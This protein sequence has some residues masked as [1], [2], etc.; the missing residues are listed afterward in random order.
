M[1]FSLSDVCLYIRYFLSY[2]RPCKLPIDRSVADVVAS[3]LYRF[4]TSWPLKLFV[5][6]ICI[7]GSHKNRPG[8]VLV[9]VR[10]KIYVGR[11]EMC[12]IPIGRDDR[13]G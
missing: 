11:R 8:K 1:N 12:D 5:Y 4:E 9:A 2:I 7:E 13:D 10:W 3:I 6:T